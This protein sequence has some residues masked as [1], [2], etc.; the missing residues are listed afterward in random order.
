MRTPQFQPINSIRQGQLAWDQ[1]RLSVVVPVY[2]E[3]DTVEVLLRTV[4]EVHLALEVIV[5][6]DGSTDGTREVLL[7]LEKEDLIDVLLLQDV[8]R[9]KGAA[10][11]VGFRCATGDI[12][13][14]QDADL[15]YDPHE[16]PKL[17]EP[18]LAGK[19]DAVY[20]SRFLGG[21]HRVLFFWHMIGNRLLT[22]LSNMLT[23][24]NLTDMETCYK[25][26]H[27]DLLKH[28]PLSANRFGFEPEV[29]A[30]LAQARARIYELP[31]SYDGRL[32]HEGKKINWKDGVAAFYHI[33]RSNIFGPKAA[34][35]HVPKVQPWEDRALT[36]TK[37]TE[38][39]DRR[40]EDSLSSVFQDDNKPVS[41]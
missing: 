35:W 27:A 4:R 32:Y 22:L 36:E 17:M 10:L 29:T 11:R 26:I 8:N 24:L 1:V 37:R 21:A 33:L 13:A 18:I 28:L 40:V 39:N 31:I 19:A 14:V 41:G 7:R 2:N 34:Q 12:I 5:V 20:G 23:D 38:L 16:I 9:G 30:R 3:I 25:V 15:E 6:D